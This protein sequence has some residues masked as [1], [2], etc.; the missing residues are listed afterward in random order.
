MGVEIKNDGS[1][2]WTYTGAFNKTHCRILWIVWLCVMLLLFSCI[3]IMSAVI[4]LPDEMNRFLL[5]ISL[6]LAGFITVIFALIWLRERFVAKKYSYTIDDK[7][8]SVAYGRYRYL[9]PDQVKSLERRQER[10]AIVIKTSLIP[11]EIFVSNE[12]YN[13]IWDFLTAHCPNGRI[14]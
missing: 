6:G 8:L 4:G 14:E 5:W 9:F 3:G 7:K 2:S 12:H 13:E 10:N 11:T 1:M